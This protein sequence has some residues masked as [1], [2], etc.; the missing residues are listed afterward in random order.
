MPITHASAS[1]PT[2]P[3]DCSRLHVG[4][5][6]AQTNAPKADDV[7]QACLGDFYFLR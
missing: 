6:E 7:G 2:Y 1:D 5:S 3:T 4:Q